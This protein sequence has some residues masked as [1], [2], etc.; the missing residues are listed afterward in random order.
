LQHTKDNKEELE[1]VLEQVKI[2]TKDE[3]Y[4]VDRL[5]RGVVVAYEKIS[6][7][8]QIAEPITTHKIDQI[9]KTIDQYRQDI[10]NLQEQLLP[11]N[12]RR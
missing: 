2:E 10:E 12:P 4:H 7:S 8:V 3:K 9:V 1:L 11:T 6:K 5:E